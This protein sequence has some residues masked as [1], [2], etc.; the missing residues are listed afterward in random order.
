MKSK[1]ECGQEMMKEVKNV[2]RM[3]KGV[4]IVDRKS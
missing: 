2:G 1:K 3:I 4:K